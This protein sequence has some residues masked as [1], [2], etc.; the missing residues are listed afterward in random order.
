M[1]C[2]TRV[3]A[4]ISKTRNY[5][6]GRAIAALT[7]LSGNY[8]FYRARLVTSLLFGPRLLLHFAILSHWGISV[9]SYGYSFVSFVIL[10]VNYG[11]LF[12]EIRVFY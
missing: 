3:L 5:A 2:F 4:I 10:M 12:R 1:P 8:G 6:L 9:V 7:A 11:Q